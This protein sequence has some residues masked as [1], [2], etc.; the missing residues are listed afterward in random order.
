MY[1]KVTPRP[2]EELPVELHEQQVEPDERDTRRHRM[3]RWVRAIVAVGALAVTIIVIV[4]LVSG[5]DHG[6]GR[7]QPDGPADAPTTHVPPVDHG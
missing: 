7:H 1:S 4:M 5:A 6:P 3:P 2:N